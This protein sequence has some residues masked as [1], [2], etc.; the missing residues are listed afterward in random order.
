MKKRFLIYNT[1]EQVRA[2]LD[3]VNRRAQLTGNTTL[4]DIEELPNGKFG[5]PIWGRIVSKV[6]GTI[7]NR[8]PTEVELPDEIPEE[9]KEIVE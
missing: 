6:V 2:A 8:V 4:V 9:I 5:L 1:R 7:H 3:Y